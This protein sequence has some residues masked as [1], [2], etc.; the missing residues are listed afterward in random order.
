MDTILAVLVIAGIILWFNWFWI[1]KIILKSKLRSLEEKRLST[2]VGHVYQA[3]SQDDY[4]GFSNALSVLSRSDV[5][6]LQKYLSSVKASSKLLRLYAD[7]HSQDPAALYLLGSSLVDE[8]WIARGNGGGNEV[9]QEQV[10]Q[11]FNYLQDA[12]VT[13]RKVLSLSPDYVEV[14]APLIRV[15]MGMGD[16]AASRILYND[17]KNIEP[18]RLDY[19][20]AMLMHLTEKWGGSHDDMFSFARE[21]AKEGGADFAAGL[22]TAAHDEYWQSLDEKEANRYYK[23]KNV[24]EELLAVIG[25]VSNEGPHEDFVIRYQKI[26]AQN[27]LASS[28]LYLKE[29]KKARLVFSAI[30]ENYTHYP[31]AYFDG[32][33]GEAYLR[34]RGLAG[35]GSV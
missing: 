7:E 3:F 13:L 4:A 26:L 35:A 29:K 24:K 10:N 32:T 34:Y 25:A 19:A 30:G 9:D 28:L 20:L 21:Q 6:E 23:N 11:F 2:S 31:W 5:Y 8:A 14:Y 33:P 27:Y 22:I 12:D 15:Q 16:I 17:A 18:G 1:K